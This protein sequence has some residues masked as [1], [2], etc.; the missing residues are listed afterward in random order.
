MHRT[1]FEAG[2]KYRHQLRQEPLLA[3]KCHL[4]QQ[5]REG[6]LFVRE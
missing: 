1:A 4:A 2:E 5:Q 3:S 6:Q